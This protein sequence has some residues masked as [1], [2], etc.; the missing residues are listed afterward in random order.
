MKVK[1]NY[2]AWEEYEAN[3]ERALA[4]RPVCD[5]CGRPIKEDFYY[6]INGENICDDC[7]EVNYLRYVD[8]ED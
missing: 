7:L 2:E 6:Y 5:Y 8:L 1:D 4:E 3:L